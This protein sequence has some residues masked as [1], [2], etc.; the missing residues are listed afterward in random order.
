LEVI[1]N[2]SKIFTTTPEVVER[3]FCVKYYSKMS[4]LSPSENSFLK[5]IQHRIAEMRIKK[6]ITQEDLAG[7]VE[8]A[9]RTVQ[10][11][12]RKKVIQIPTWVLYRLAKA[13]CC[14]IHDFFP[15]DSNPKRDKDPK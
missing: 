15:N 3:V 13:L 5:E 14:S 9:P 2:Y 7:K 4:N 6:G 11:W 8:V 10:R 12:E 1:L